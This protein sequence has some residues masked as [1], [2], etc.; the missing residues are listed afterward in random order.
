M[1]RFVLVLVLLVSL[2]SPVI[3]AVAPD[4]SVPILLYHRFGPT[5]ADGMTITT[6]VFESHMKYLRDNGYKVIPLRQLV[7][8]YQGK[9]AAPA[10]KSVVIVEDDAH[11]TVYSDMLPI[12]RKYRYPVTIFVYPSAISN[13]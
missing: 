2:S 9:G 12:I 3:A 10:P 1:V 7:Q 4:V 11:K 13:A 6:P 5:V 8:W